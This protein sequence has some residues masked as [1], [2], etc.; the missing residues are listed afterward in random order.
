V[1]V[2]GREMLE[3]GANITLNDLIKNLKELKSKCKKYQTSLLNALLSNLKW[4]ASNQIRNFA[5][6]A[7]NIGNF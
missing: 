4:F 1:T 3:I 6:L 5:T 2:N 7:G